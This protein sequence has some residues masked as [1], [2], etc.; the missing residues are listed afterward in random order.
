MVRRV[1]LYAVPAK[2]CRVFVHGRRH[3]LLSAIYDAINLKRQNYWSVLK[4]VMPIAAQKYVRALPQCRG[5]T[6]SRQLVLRVSRRLRALGHFS[7]P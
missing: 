5:T 7:L 3:V 4:D 6:A 2:R 1:G